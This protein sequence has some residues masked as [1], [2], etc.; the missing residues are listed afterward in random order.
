VS[1]AVL[2]DLADACRS[3]GLLV[4]EVP[5][6][7]TKRRPG[8]FG[9][10]G[11]LVHHT[12]GDSDGFGY[13]VWLA[14][15]G[16]RDLAAPLCQVALGR[17]GTV[18]VCAAGRS[19]HAGR[20]R[21]SGPM[22]A[23]DGN[24]LYIGI[25]AMNNGSEGFSR[26]QYEAYVALCAALCRWYGWPASHVRGHRETS[27]TG[28]VDPGRIDLDKFRRDIDVQMEDDMPSLEEIEALLDR[29]LDEK[30][31]EL[32]EVVLADPK[33]DSG[34]MPRKVAW[35]MHRAAEASE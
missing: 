6:W 25:E 22:P 13:A 1:E 12:G 23:G 10:G 32:G 14:N 5:G 9:P 2:T 30:F 24:T 21:A 26:T 7:P 17:D 35:L 27:V 19:N 4:V 20:A 28:K 34:R 31:A 11:I 16:R 33:T 15:V 8:S 3:S 29:K 18:Y